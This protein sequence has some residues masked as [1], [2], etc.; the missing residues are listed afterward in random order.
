[1]IVDEGSIQLGGR[2]GGRHAE[3][4]LQ[5]LPGTRTPDEEC[6]GMIVM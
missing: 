5:A 4:I 1:V 6:F 3:T 2:L